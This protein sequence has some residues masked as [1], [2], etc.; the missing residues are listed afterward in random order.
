MAENGEYISGQPAH[1]VI[2]RRSVD[3]TITVPDVLTYDGD[4]KEATFT[5]STGDFADGDNVT[6]ELYYF[7][8]LANG[9]PYYS[10]EE[11]TLQAPTD[12]GS[13]TV[14]LVITTENEDDY[15]FSTP[16]TAFK[17]SKAE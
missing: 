1:Y 16:S 8:T 5:V 10:A 13:Y 4:E 14:V 15:V 6:T 2:T 3:S 12:A 11:P 9:D 7:G 17:I